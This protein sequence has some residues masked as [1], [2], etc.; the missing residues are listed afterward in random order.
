MLTIKKVQVVPLDENY[1]K[2]IDSFD[3]ADDQTK[4]APSA[5]AT[6]DYIDD[7]A[8]TLD[9]KIVN[10]INS[11]ILSGTSNPSSSLGEN[12]DVYFQYDA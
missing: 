12:G 6:K 3:T 5:R 7:Y 8:S 1:G 2:I 10:T 4:N 11:K 9:T